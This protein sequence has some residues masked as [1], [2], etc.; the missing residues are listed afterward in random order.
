MK[1]EASK[2]T[3][4]D[5][6]TAT[7]SEQ[8]QLSQARSISASRLRVLAALCRHAAVPR[9]G[10]ENERNAKKSTATISYNQQCRMHDII[11]AKTNKK[12]T[13]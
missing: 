3:A 13:A 7:F 1:N 11:P 9:K 4:T 12:C 8:T 10:N 6:D 2:T 5:L